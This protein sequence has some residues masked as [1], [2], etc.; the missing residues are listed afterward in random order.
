MFGSDVLELAVAI[1]FV[2][3]LVSIMASAIR[4]GIEGFLKT[5]ATHLEA[6]IRELL[7]DSDGSRLAKQFF[8]HP[9]IYS[10]YAGKYTPGKT[11]KLPMALT[12]GRN[13]PSYI[14][15]RNFALALMDMVARGPTVDTNTS[16]ATAG[17]ITLQA[18]RANISQ[19]QSPPVQRVL[20]TAI[21]SAE[22]D[23]QS[24]QANIEAWYDSAMDRVSGWYKRST[25]WMLLVIGFV[26]AVTLNVNTIRI[27]DYLY[28]D[29]ATREAL[30]ARAQSAA[31]DPKYPSRKYED[32]QQE[33]KSLRLPIGG[34][35][36]LK[37]L[38]EQTFSSL[39]GWL[40]T[41]IAATLGAPFWFDLLNKIMVIRSTVKPHEKSPEEGS[42][43]RQPG[44]EQAKS[45]TL[46]APGTVARG[47]GQADVSA[48]PD[49]ADLIDGCGVQLASVTKDEDLP[50][51]EGGVS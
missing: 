40:L 4:E 34:T 8:E 24:A 44:G 16:Q 12:S 25:Q 31:A 15:S 7:H 20:L 45:V 2:F 29:K 47:S 35:D 19:I 49:P 11:T 46:Q 27:A 10:L 5:R 39:G 14:P 50:S 37:Q 22:G 9:L 43:D 18:V 41:A 23:L 28:R 33:L 30:I 21:D 26:L 17:A 32:I 38:E 13:L 1:I 3:L 6:G 42:E 51:A 36:Q 48:A